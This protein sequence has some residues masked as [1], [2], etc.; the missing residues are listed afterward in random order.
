VFIL[1]LPFLFIFLALLKRACQAT[2]DKMFRV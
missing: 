2:G 1:S